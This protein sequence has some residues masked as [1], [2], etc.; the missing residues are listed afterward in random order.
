[1]KNQPIRTLQTPAQLEADIQD[2][3]AIEPRFEKVYQQVGVPD[4]RRNRG[5]F[6]QLMRAMVGQQLSVAATARIYPKIS[7]MGDRS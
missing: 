7:P 6:E 1:M 2:L 5:G 4:L 3:I